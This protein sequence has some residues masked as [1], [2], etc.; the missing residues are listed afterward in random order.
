MPLKADWVDRGVASRS[1]AHV[2]GK[3]RE[4]QGSHSSHSFALG[5][6][7]LASLGGSVQVSFRIWR[8]RREI[9]DRR[10]LIVACDCVT[11]NCLAGLDVVAMELEVFVASRCL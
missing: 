6:Q 1:N 3:T 9:G 7:M 4:E 10:R 11:M 5:S 8:V 2:R